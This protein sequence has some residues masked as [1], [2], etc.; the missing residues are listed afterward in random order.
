[1]EKKLTFVRSLSECVC[2]FE[3]NNLSVHQSN[4]ALFDNDDFVE[5]LVRWRNKNAKY[6]VT[7]IPTN[8]I[9][10]KAWLK[11]NFKDGGAN[12][13]FVISDRLENRVAGHVG[14]S[15]KEN[16]PGCFEI[17][18]VLRGE[19]TSV[20]F[21]MQDALSETLNYC[22]RSL[23]G[24]VFFADCFE[25]SKAAISLYKRLKFKERGFVYLIKTPVSGG[26]KWVKSDV[27]ED[28]CIR[29]YHLE[30]NMEPK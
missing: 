28:G 27:N 20:N 14:I 11:A 15:E 29:M 4:E 22:Q 23:G 17:H 8:S 13:L 6:F 18:S 2:I 10:T 21:L 5:I 3:S 26:H 12:T 7:Q 16:H 1:M 24:R 9:K 19:K 30:L 25:T